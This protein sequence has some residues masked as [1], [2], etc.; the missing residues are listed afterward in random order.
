METLQFL[1]DHNNLNIKVVDKIN[2]YKY[3]LE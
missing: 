3:K 2:S 1:K